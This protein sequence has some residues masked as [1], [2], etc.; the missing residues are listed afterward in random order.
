MSLWSLGS[1]LTYICPFSMTRGQD[2]FFPDQA[3]ADYI[4]DAYALLRLSPYWRL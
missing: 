1:F 3:L 2:G 4:L